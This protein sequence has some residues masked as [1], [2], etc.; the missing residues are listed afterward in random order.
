MKTVI[1]SQPEFQIISADIRAPMI[2][3]E[4]S[5]LKPEVENLKYE[6]LEN[7]LGYMGKT[8]GQHAFDKPSC[9]SVSQDGLQAFREDRSLL[10]NVI[11]HT[12][13]FF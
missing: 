7:L 8:G 1:E 9:N 4:N 3:N 13:F 11:V 12:T 5:R 2:V 10:E 6:F